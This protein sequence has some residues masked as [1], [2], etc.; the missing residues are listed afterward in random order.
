MSL[1]QAAPPSATV[2]RLDHSPPSI[3]DDRAAF[4]LLRASRRCA[5]ADAYPRCQNLTVRQLAPLCRVLSTYETFAQVRY[6]GG[7]AT[8]AIRSIVAAINTSPLSVDRTG[9]PHGPSGR[10]H[11]PPGTAPRRASFSGRARNGALAE[12][13]PSRVGSGPSAAEHR[14]TPTCRWKTIRVCAGAA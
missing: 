13:Q 12:L 6:H 2:W 1:S 8:H 10:T 5:A 4:N 3:Q 9:Y 11:C 7:T 14:M